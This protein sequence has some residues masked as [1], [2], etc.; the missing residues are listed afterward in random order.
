M[1]PDFA[2]QLEEV[3]MHFDAQRDTT[4]NLWIDSVQKK[5]YEVY[6]EEYDQ[7]MDV[8]LNGDHSF[9]NKMTGMGL[10][11]LLS[12]IDKKSSEMESLSDEPFREFSSAQSGRR[13]NRG[14]NAGGYMYEHQE[15]YICNGEDVHD[16]ELNRN[17][18]YLFSDEVPANELSRNNLHEV[19]KV[20]KKGNEI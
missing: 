3:K 7:S 5:F 15:V 19:S 9:F 2:A 13:C 8:Y 14:R 18:N 1:I 17:R 6:I 10:N 16:A 12:F 11:E 4:A 20:R